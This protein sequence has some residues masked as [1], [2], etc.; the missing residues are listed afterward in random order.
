MGQPGRALGLLR[1]REVPPVCNC[2]CGLSRWYFHRAEARPAP[3]PFP[4][5]PSCGCCPSSHRRAPPLLQQA[6]L[7]LCGHLDPISFFLP[8]PI[9]GKQPWTDCTANFRNLLP[10]EAISVSSTS[11]PGVSYTPL[12]APPPRA[13]PSSLPTLR[14][15]WI[16]NPVS[17]WFLAEHWVP[18]QTWSSL[19]LGGSHP[20]LSL[21]P[22]TVPGTVE[23][24]PS[25]G[26][27]P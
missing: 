1:E 23:P 16:I 5:W 12:R 24:C 10:Q 27:K 26:T 8:P 4:L 15:T 6:K 14:L 19:P 18:G 25:P 7:L 9:S 22:L 2:I 11:S 3:P 13:P 20:R 17:I 21:P